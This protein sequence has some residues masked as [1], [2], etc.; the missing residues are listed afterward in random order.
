M[1]HLSS[2]TVSLVLN[3][4]PGI[5]K[6]TRSRVIEAAHQFGCEELLTPND[7]KKKTILFVVYRKH[8]IRGAEKENFSQI[9]SEVIEGVEFQAREK[10]FQLMVSYTNQQTYREEAARIR[11]TRVDGVL[12]LATE[13]EEEQLSTFMEMQIPVVVLDNY[14]EQKQLDYVT[15]NNELGVFQAVS[16]LAEQGHRNIGY[17]HL[18]HNAN[19]FTER[20]FG[21]LRAMEKLGIPVDRS[22]ILEMDT[23]G[24]TL[25]DD[26][27]HKLNLLDRMPTAF[28]ADNDIVAIGANRALR[29]L[30]YRV[31]EDVSLVG[32]DDMALSEMTDPPLTTVRV[33]KRQMGMEAVNTIIEKIKKRS[34]GNMKIE[35]AT[36]LVVR[37]S[38]KQLKK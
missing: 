11:K 25:Y 21:F 24:D 32:F 35:I 30:G 28:F 4:R 15:I 3:N 36:K 34:S 26:V 13:M 9:F 38:V 20:Y 10:D 27:E 1:L 31:P 14:V 5:S 23:Q 19:N 33:S 2:S 29:R 8:G 37:Q 18:T 17:L 6:T 22:W 7:G 12:L 16:H